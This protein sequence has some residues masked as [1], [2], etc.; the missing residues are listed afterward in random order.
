MPAQQDSLKKQLSRSGEIKITVTGRKTGRAI[1]LPVWFVLDGDTLNLLPVEGSDSQWYQNVLKNPKIRID[2]GSAHAE[3][4]AAPTTDASQVSSVVEKF[5]AKYGAK[6]VKKYYSKFD[7][8]VL[9]R[10]S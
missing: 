7:V 1:T 6:D 4:Q 5:R 8:A 9:A 10:A 2:A 3:L